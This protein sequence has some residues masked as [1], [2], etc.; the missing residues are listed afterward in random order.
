M[1][2]Y[3]CKLKG[4]NCV[5]V[6]EFESG[7]LFT[8]VSLNPET[9]CFV[10]CFN[11]KM[12]LQGNAVFGFQKKKFLGKYFEKKYDKHKLYCSAH[13]NEEKK[14]KVMLHNDVR[15]PINFIYCFFFPA[16]LLFSEQ[17]RRWPDCLDG[18][19]KKKEFSGISL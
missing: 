17:S 5:T 13:I 2:K 9:F 3:F 7:L 16:L 4:D 8:D 1:N 11:D 15:I 10:F 14:F 12:T 18:V 6:L 19:D